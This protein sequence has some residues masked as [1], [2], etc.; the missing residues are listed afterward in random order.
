[1]A[2]APFSPVTAAE[3]L[4]GQSVQKR[5]GDLQTPR[6]QHI[7]T[8]YDPSIHADPE[9]PGFVDSTLVVKYRD[10]P[11]LGVDGKPFTIN[12]VPVERR[13]AVAANG[14]VID[15]HLFHDR[16]LDRIREFYTLAKRENPKIRYDDNPARDYI[17]N[18]VNYVSE[19]VDPSDERRVMPMHYSNNTAGNKPKTLAAFEGEEIKELPR[20]AALTAAYMDPSQRGALKEGEVAEVEAELQ[21]MA[22][23]AKP[24]KSPLVQ[25]K[26]PDKK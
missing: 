2:S 11:L 19:Q 14:E 3:P 10:E 6:G 18:V 13:W 12:E 21:R 15:Q 26:Q 24:I 16:Y 4:H 5:L 22:E 7:P 9:N 23:L 20:L 17:P 8:W 1:M 25:K